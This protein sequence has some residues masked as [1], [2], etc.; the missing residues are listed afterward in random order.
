MQKSLY[1]LTATLVAF[2]AIASAQSLQ[3]L[4]TNIPIFFNNVL[5]PFL[6]GIAF[7]IFVINAVRFFIIEGS[8]EE[9][10]KKAKALAIY[11]VA[12]FVFL[13]IFSGIVNLLVETTELGGK[14]APVSDYY[15]RANKLP[16][17]CPP[18]ET[19]PC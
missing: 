18:E 3:N 2:P 11:S 19:G 7:L 16:S 4:L 9:G 1:A 13:I 6:F 5:I 17:D 12:A 8:N 15:E 10:R 14:D